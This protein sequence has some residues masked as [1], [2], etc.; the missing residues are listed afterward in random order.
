MEHYHEPFEAA[1]I[2]DAT[3]H[4]NFCYQ[5]PHTKNSISEKS[6]GHIIPLSLCVGLTRQCFWVESLCRKVL[7]SGSVDNVLHVQTKPAA[8]RAINVPGASIMQSVWLQLTYLASAL[9][10][11]KLYVLLVVQTSPAPCSYLHMLE[12]EELLRSSCCK[13]HIL[14]AATVIA[15]S[16]DIEDIGAIPMQPRG[17]APSSSASDPNC[18]AVVVTRWLVRA[19][20][21]SAIGWKDT[22]QVA[23]QKVDTA[24]RG[25]ATTTFGMLYQSKLKISRS[26]ILHNTWSGATVHAV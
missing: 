23:L 17:P 21:D 1:R 19:L 11:A 12:A 26:C 6:P 18:S 9:F 20:R 5:Q 4:P 10:S 8:T 3:P 13:L 15:I 24:P 22:A 14:L 7:T 16:R 25:L 2:R